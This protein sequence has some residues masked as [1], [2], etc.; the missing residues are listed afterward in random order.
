MKIDSSHIAFSSQHTRVSQVSVEESLRAWVG[1][2]RPDFE[3]QGAENT[4]LGRVPVAPASSVA[5]SGQARQALLQAAAQP[6]LPAPAQGGSANLAAG[7]SPDDALS[8][9]QAS[10]A[11]AVDAQAEA[12]DSDPKLKLLVT[13]IEAFTG[14]KVKLLDAS[15]LTKAGHTPAADVPS[16]ATDTAV[17]QAEQPQGWGIEY[18]RRESVYEFEQTSFTAE[19][20]IRTADGKTLQFSVAMQMTREFASESTFSLRAGDGVRKDPLVINFGGTAAQLTDQK[21]VFDIDSDG[22]DDSISFVGG[23]SG[24]LA[25]DKNGNGSIDDGSELFGTQSGNGFADLA[26]YDEDSN[27]WIDEADSVF[28]KLLIWTRDGQG[29]DQLTSL[30][31]RKVGALYLGQTATPFDIKGSDNT[32]HGQVRGTGLYVGEDGRVGTLQQVDLVV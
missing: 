7:S 19:G 23:A 8:G 26:A 30:A 9:Q 29:E 27:G 31:Q 18:D 20:V 3:G 4:G 1:N 15:E 12:I 21:F 11:D 32:M 22:V 16:K 24:F 6:A 10:G 25:L 2:Q 13:L 14:R 5:I 17:A 28:A